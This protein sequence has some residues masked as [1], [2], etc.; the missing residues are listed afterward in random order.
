MNVHFW[1]KRFEHC[2]GERAHRA[3]GQNVDSGDTRQAFRKL[4]APLER[5]TYAVGLRPVV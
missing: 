3:L 5:P 2:L 4:T 1:A